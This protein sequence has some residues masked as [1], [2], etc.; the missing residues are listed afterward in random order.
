MTTA[1]NVT[2]TLRQIWEGRGAVRMETVVAT[3]SSD[4]WAAI[5]NPTRLGRWIAEV[6]GDLHLGGMFSAHFTSG[7][8]GV[9]R[10]DVCD[11]DVRLVV[12]MSPGTDDETTIEAT[13]SV[14]EGG[15]RLVVEERG[16]PLPE[17][18]A[19]GAG[20]QVHIEDLR[21][22]VNNAEQSKWRE[23]WLALTPEYAQMARS[24]R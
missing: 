15:T 13:L 19:H 1:P 2:G 20:W 14:V 12:T 10:V 23:R 18:A 17:I 16:I 11:T 4:L 9:G 8:E 3:D 24:I 21:A 7:W 5:T 22:Y 6:K